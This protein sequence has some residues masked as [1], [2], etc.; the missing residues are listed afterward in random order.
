MQVSFADVDGIR[1]RY[2]HTGTGHPL[3]LIHGVGVSADC[4][5]RNIDALGEEFAVYAPDMLGHGFTDAV[6]Y[7]G[8]SP[9]PRIVRHLGRLAELLGLERYSVLGSSFGALIAALMYFERPE[10]V[11]SLVLVGSG[12]VFHPPDEQAETLRAALANG[13]SAMADPTLESCRRRLANVC[14]D[15][16]S[17]PEEMLLVQLTSYALPDRLPAYRATIAGLIASVGSLE[18]RVY[19]RLEQIR[20]PCLVITGREDIRA[21]YRHTEEGCRRIPGAELVMLERCG[22]LPFLEHPGR[23]NALVRQ[24]LGQAAIRSATAG[25]P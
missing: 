21:S 10:R 16:A 5:V 11:P 6:D 23:F 12:S 14:F 4:F 19:A 8:D 24:F 7:R 2:L 9:Q 20:V 13:T 25:S 22:H 3:F 15:P 17:V 1:T 18:H